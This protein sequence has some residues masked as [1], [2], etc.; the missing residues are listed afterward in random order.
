QFGDGLSNIVW[1]TAFAAV[2]SGLACVKLEKWWKFIFPVFF[3]I[4]GVQA[5]LIVIATLTGFGA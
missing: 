2:M 4:V 3:A 5:V 1:P